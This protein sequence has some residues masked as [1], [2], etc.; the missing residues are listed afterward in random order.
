MRKVIILVVVAFTTFLTVNAQL[1]MN[2]TG[3]VTIG[4]N[5]VQSGTAA[6]LDIAGN[7]GAAG[8]RNFRVTF[9]IGVGL[10]NTELSGLAQ[11]G[12]QDWVWTALYAKQGNS[13]YSGYF[14]G[15]CYVNGNFHFTSDSRLKE[16]FRKIENPLQSVLKLK[17]VKYDLQKVTTSTSDKVDEFNEERRKDNLGFIAQDVLNIAP[18]L[19]IADPAS[20]NYAINYNGFIPILVEAFKE[21]QTIIESLQ[22]EIQDLKK[23]SSSST[24]KSASTTGTSILQE[25]TANA[26]YQNS[27]NPFSHGT[28]IEYSLAEN[29][30]K[31]MICIYDMNGTQLKSILLNLNRY[32]NITI[33]GSELRAGM[34]MY[35]LFA[36]GQL[37]DTKRMVLT[38]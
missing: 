29:V 7:R 14:D 13:T 11:I 24:L 36:D 20:G 3:G 32:G 16:N 26:L 21:Q 5:P 6:W 1:S 35:S 15:D 10:A 34:Y 33:N 12:S 27:P 19:V 22:S 4:T 25:N 9:P 8:Q 23:G 17:G 28:T 2:S 30:L 37:I 31:A 18:E 38:D